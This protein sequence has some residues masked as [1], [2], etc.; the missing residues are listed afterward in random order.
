MKDLFDL[1]PEGVL[2]PEER[3]RLYATV[4]R[5]RGHFGRPGSGP[6]GETC[7]TCA[8]YTSVRH[9]DKT[10]PKCGRAQAAWTHGP[11]SDIRRKDPACHGWEPAPARPTQKRTS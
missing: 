10:Y 2:T 9:H 3:R 1:L 7:G 4:P 6:E 11:G 8:H 5:R